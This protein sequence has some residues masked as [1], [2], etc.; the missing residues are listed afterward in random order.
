MNHIGKLAY[1]LLPLPPS[2]AY[3]VNM[4]QK[5]NMRDISELAVKLRS[6]HEMRLGNLN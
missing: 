4:R 1:L 2:I 3:N 5:M 6:R